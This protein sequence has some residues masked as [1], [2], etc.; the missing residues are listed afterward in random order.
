M[1]VRF[2]DVLSLDGVAAQMAAST[3]DG[4]I[5]EVARLLARSSEGLSVDAVRAV[6]IDR[7]R[8]ASTGVGSGVAIPHGRLRGLQRMV[9]S[10]SVHR[11]GLHFDAVDGQPVHLFVGIVGPDVDSAA[12]LR[13]LARASRILRDPAAREA[14]LACETDGALHATFLALD[15]D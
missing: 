2:S 10:L 3:K 11:N 12:H 15:A 7:E 14:L 1:V 13:L 8:L 4:A 6:L 9:A 5:G